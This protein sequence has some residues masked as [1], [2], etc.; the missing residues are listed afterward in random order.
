M[1]R[2]IQKTL[3]FAAL[4]CVICSVLVSTAAVAFKNLRQVTNQ[5]L[6]RRKNVLEAAGLKKPGDRRWNKIK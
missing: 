2:S 1:Q 5:I 3:G 4:V 6:D